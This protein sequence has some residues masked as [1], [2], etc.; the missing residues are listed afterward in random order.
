MHPSPAYPSSDLVERPIPRL[1]TPSED[2]YTVSPI[3]DM[4]LMKRSFSTTIFAGDEPLKQLPLKHTLTTP[5]KP[6]VLKAIPK[7]KY[8]ISRTPPFFSTLV[9]ILQNPVTLNIAVT[10]G[11]P[12]TMI[13]M[14]VILEILAAIS[15]RDGGMSYIQG[16]GLF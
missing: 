8:V 10:L 4:D 6:D 15:R 13:V 7:Q 14:G 5:H 1:L 12:L 16:P 9:N 11:V 2:N 3:S